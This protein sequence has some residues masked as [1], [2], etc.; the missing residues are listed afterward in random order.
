MQVVKIIVSA[1]KIILSAFLL[2]TLIVA[3]VA[4]YVWTYGSPVPR[5]LADL[6]ITSSSSGSHISV[7]IDGKIL[8]SSDAVISVKQHRKKHCIIVVVREAL[9]RR[10][11]REGRFHMLITVPDD[12]DEIAFENSRNVIWHR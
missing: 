8:S 1:L 5:N 9:V 12:V 2:T 4:L 3:V 7:H 10:G 6:K 11:N